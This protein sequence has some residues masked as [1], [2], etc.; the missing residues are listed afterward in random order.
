[1]IATN[2]ARVMKRD[3]GGDFTIG[4]SVW[5]TVGCPFDITEILRIFRDL[6]LARKQEALYMVFL[7][8]KAYEEG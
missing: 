7:L 6:C 3:S 4:E 5:G 2:L 8:A 1:M